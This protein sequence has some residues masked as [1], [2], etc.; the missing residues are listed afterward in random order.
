MFI[1]LKH[2]CNHNIVNL[3]R[4]LMSINVAEITH[5]TLLNL[6]KFSWKMF[7]VVYEIIE[8]QEKRKEHNHINQGWISLFYVSKHTQIN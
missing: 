3:L 4:F 5:W 2:V 1:I 6:A 8:I 7:I